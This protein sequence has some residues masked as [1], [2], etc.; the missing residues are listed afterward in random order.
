MPR[1]VGATRSEGAALQASEAAFR[2]IG[3]GLFV[4]QKAKPAI[5]EGNRNPVGLELLSAAAERRNYPE[6]KPNRDALKGRHACQQRRTL[7]FFRYDDGAVLSSLGM[8]R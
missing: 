5:R 2:R 6:A 4:P 7:Q 8:D 1:S 3:S